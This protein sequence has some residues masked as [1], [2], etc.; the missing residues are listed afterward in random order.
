M[1]NTVSPKGVDEWLSFLADKPLPVRASTLTRLKKALHSPSSTLV[2]LPPIISHDPVLCFHLCCEAQRLLASR[3]AKVTSLSHAVQALGFD[4]IEQLVASLTILK[5]NPNSTPQKMYFRA[6]A[7]S[8]HAATQVA[9]WLHLRNASYRE[10]AKMASLFYGFIHW[11]MWLYA[12]FHKEAYQEKVYKHNQDV[13]LAE[14]DVFGC[15]LQELGQKLGALLHVPELTL[16]ALNHDSSPTSSL[17]GLL[18]LKAMGDA[19]L[20]IKDLRE[21]NHLIQQPFFPVKLS[22]WLSLT[23][24]RGW[25]SDKAKRIF[26]IITDY[27]QLRGY[28]AQ[29]RLHAQCAESARQYHLP[30]VLSPATELLWISSTPYI[31]GLF[32]ITEKAQTESLYPPF[33]IPVSTPIP[34]TSEV[35]TTQERPTPEF[36]DSELYKH[37]ATQFHSADSGYSRPAQVLKD[38]LKGLKLGLGLERVLLLSVDIPNNRI[39]TSYQVGFGKDHEV[40]AFEMAYDIPSLLKRLC[41]KPANHVC[42]KSN[43]Q[44]THQAL[45]HDFLRHISP[46]DFIVMSI[47]CNKTPIGIV[48]A[49]RIPN[50][51]ELE[52]F[53]C[54]RFRYLCSSATL[55]MKYMKQD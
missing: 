54:E 25:D 33:T 35:D 9:D 37:I 29:A 34:P 50:S 27:L 16:E 11:L 55:A 45:P 28:E 40:A 10:E 42:Q 19:R 7:D 6:I 39:Q 30:G 18:H 49:D 52:D 44:Q 21:V 26:E 8:H 12:P 38:L 36:A 53:Y 2:T 13:V 3:H 32:S 41:E 22:N 31:P 20:E 1:S 24:T 51:L 47:F 46:S 23:T 43:R 5:L 14:H 17:L 48:Y 4:R 15:T